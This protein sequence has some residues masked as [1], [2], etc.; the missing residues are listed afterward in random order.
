MVSVLHHAYGI[1]SGAVTAAYSCGS[2]PGPVLDEVFPNLR[3]ARANAVNIVPANLPG[4]RY[5]LDRVLPDLA[6]R[7]AGTALRVPVRAASLADLTV[8]LRHPAGAAE[9]NHT[10][11]TAATST[12]KGYLDISQAPLVSSDVLGSPASCVVDSAL[13]AVTGDLVRVAGWYDNEWGY[14]H[15]LLDLMRYL[16]CAR[17]V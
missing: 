11:W 9:V 13:T 8:R 3:M 17:P 10:L 6:G 2:R 15:R 4:V 5:A 1:R 7:I 12:L 16:A 14:A